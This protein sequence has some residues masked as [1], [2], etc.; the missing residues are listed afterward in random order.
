M[1]LDPPPQCVGSADPRIRYVSGS[2]PLQ[3]HHGNVSLAEG[4][5][6]WSHETDPVKNIKKYWNFQTGPVKN[7]T[8]PEI[9]KW[10]PQL[11]VLLWPIDPQKI[12]F[13]MKNWKNLKHLMAKSVNPFP[14]QG[15]IYTYV[16]IC[17]WT[18]IYQYQGLL[19]SLNVFIWYI[20]MANVCCQGLIYLYVLCCCSLHLHC[21][22]VLP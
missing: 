14:A 15:L 18:L 3:I 9:F 2:D 5:V 17:S 13:L 16:K 7:Q 21:S 12:Y 4:N 6:S 1:L 19:S 11:P 20:C 22:V 8:I 10:I